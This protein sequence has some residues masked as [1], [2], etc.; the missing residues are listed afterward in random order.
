VDEA[1]IDV[2]SVQYVADVENE[3]VRTPAGRLAA[4]VPLTEVIGEGVRPF[5]RTPPAEPSPRWVGVFL[6]ICAVLFVPYIVQ[7]AFQLPAHQDTSHYR[8][9][10]VGLDVMELLALAATAWFA[11]TRSTWI[12]ISAAMA[13]A[14]LLADA[15]FDVV[16]ADSMSDRVLALVEAALIELPMAAFCLWIARHA[17][18]VADRATRLLLRRSAQQARLLSDLTDRMRSVAGRSPR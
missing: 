18:V 1:G 11:W 4:P 14:L 13:T 10:W 7:L 6:G 16:S 2:E 3:M 17:E 5:H 9:A 12:A 15:W 8:A